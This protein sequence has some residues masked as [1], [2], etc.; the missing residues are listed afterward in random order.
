MKRCSWCGREYPDETSVCAIDQQPLVSGAPQPPVQ[1]SRAQEPKIAVPLTLRGFLLLFVRYVAAIGVSYFVSYSVFFGG[2][3]MLMWAGMLGI[4]LLF[5]ASGFCGVFVGTLCLPRFNRRFGSAVLLVM[6][7]AYYIYFVTSLDILRAE[8][9]S[10]PY[11]WLVPL[12][13]GG[14]IAMILIRKTTMRNEQATSETK[15]VTVK[16]LAAQDL[17]PEIEGI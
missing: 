17:G 16:L 3:F 5:V 4:V 10:F 12:A 2:M 15:G 6:G 13:G 11:V 1:P 14:V 9:N 7:L 8:N